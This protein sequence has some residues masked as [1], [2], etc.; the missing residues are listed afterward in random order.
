MYGSDT[1]GR[2]FCLIW[3]SIFKNFHSPI[4]TKL[5]MNSG[6][7]LFLVEYLESVLNFLIYRY[8]QVKYL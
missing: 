4:N 8:F 7:I 1:C 6:R 2:I 3:K 5:L